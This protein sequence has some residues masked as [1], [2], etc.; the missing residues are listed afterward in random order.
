MYAA[1]F[2]YT[3][4]EVFVLTNAHLLIKRIGHV[5]SQLV[6]FAVYVARFAGYALVPGA[7]WNLPFDAMHGVTFGLQLVAMTGLMSQLAPP[8]MQPS[9]QGLAQGVY[10]GPGVAVGYLLGGLVYQTLGPRLLWTCSAALALLA[11]LL[12]TGLHLCLQRNDK[13]APVQSLEPVAS[14]NT[15]AEQ[16]ETEAY[17]SQAIAKERKPTS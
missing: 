6:C 5:R 12:F 10:Y 16:V 17:D 13:P 14:S 8:A 4:S 1:A 7:W 2:M 15:G 9:A 11:F 3:L